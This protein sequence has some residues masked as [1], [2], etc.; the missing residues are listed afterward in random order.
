[1]GDSQGWALQ[2]EEAVAA[3]GILFRGSLKKFNKKRTW[4]YWVIEKKKIIIIIHEVLQFPSTSIQ[5]LNY[6]YLLSMWVG[7]SLQ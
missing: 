4:K 2:D 3:P 6:E 5:I 7:M 1:M